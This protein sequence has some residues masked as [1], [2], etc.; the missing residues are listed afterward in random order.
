[1][2][3]EFSDDAKAD[4]Q[5]IAQYTLD[6]W[7]AEQEE[8]YLKRIYAKCEEILQ[9]PDRWRFRKELHPACQSARVGRHVVF[10][11]IQQETLKIAKILHQSM[12]FETHLRDDLFH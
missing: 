10:F 9:T 4:L 3:L 2:C 8:L 11:C 5:S 6:T 12:D 1:M 7:G